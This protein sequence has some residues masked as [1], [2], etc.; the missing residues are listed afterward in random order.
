MHEALELFFNRPEKYI[1]CIDQTLFKKSQKLTKI[2]YFL[3]F[4]NIYQNIDIVITKTILI[5]SAVI[6]IN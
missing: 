4:Y 1:H 5:V 6:A 2:G 3:Y